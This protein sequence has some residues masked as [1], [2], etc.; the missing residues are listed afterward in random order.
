MSF[1][2]AYLMF[3]PILNSFSKVKSDARQPELWCMLL[4]SS[5]FFK[6]F[7]EASI[8]IL[9]IV[10]FFGNDFSQDIVKTSNVTYP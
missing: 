4:N 3:I 8:K 2:V 6:K 5:T 9:K 10:R 1:L 7:E